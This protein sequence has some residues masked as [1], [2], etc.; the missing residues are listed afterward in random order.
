L[1]LRKAKLADVLGNLS[2]DVRALNSSGPTHPAHDSRETWIV[3]LSLVLLAI[4]FIAYQ[5]VWR[6][7][8]VWD[9]DELLT[10]NPTVTSLNLHAPQALSK[11][12]FSTASLD[13]YPMTYTLWW[14]EL[15]LWGNNPLGFHLVNVL[16]HGLSALL[17]WR[18]LLRLKIPSAF[19]AAAIFALHPVNV[20]SVAWISEGKN[21]LSMF[22]FMAA[23]LSYVK[24]EDDISWRWYWGSLALF[25]LALFS[26]TA[27]APLPVILLGLAWAR[28]GKIQGADVM[29]ALPFLV[30]ALAECAVTMWF[31]YHRAVGDE[32]VRADSFWS[33]LAEA[34]WAVWFYLYKAVLPVNL[35]F[36]Y[37]K[38]QI[39]PGNPVSYLPGLLLTVVLAALWIGAGKSRQTKGLAHSVEGG[40]FLALAYF[41]V[42]LLPVLGFLN[43]YFMRYS[44][45][46][47]HWQYFALIGPIVLA[48]AFVRKPALAAVILLT[49]GFL[50]WKQCGLYASSETLWRDT[51]VKNP[52]SAIVKN[53][54]SREL[55]LQN[56]VGEAII[57][58]KSVLAEH[59]DDETARFN[60]AS[61]LVRENRIDEAIV[62]YGEALRL[63]PNDAN[64]LYNLAQARVKKGDFNS[65]V[66]DF[67]EAIRMQPDFPEAWCNLGYALLQTHRQNEAV[68]AYQKALALNPDYAL[69]H[70]DLG[71]I[72]LKMGRVGDAASH[73]QQAVNTDPGF[74]EAHYNLA[75]ALLY[76][77]RVDEAVSQ[78]KDALALRLDLAAAELKL[79]AIYA[80]EGSAA[81]AVMHYEKAIK[82]QPDMP[83]ALGN[84]AWLLATSRDS[85]LRNGP[86]ALELARRADNLAKGGNPA[87]L[88]SLAAAEAECGRFEEAVKTIDAAL[89]MAEKNK[90]L[91]ASLK[92]QREYYA[93][94][95][96]YRQ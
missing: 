42:M 48:A 44:L 54:L 51:L 46:A 3:C 6:A 55:L 76:L 73:F 67:Q 21:C 33:R 34:G 87:F 66:H 2:Q 18:I 72:L 89:P 1:I 74:A 20:E 50:T 15:R 12:W 53:D 9:D 40:L 7:G 93:K 26:K 41:I 24:Y 65:A 8:F 17:L 32:V 57:L 94:R 61:A 84:L 83:Y 77:N 71:S 11:I 27:A 36:I 63:R 85:A 88:G 68:A 38:W 78:Y 45:V 79:G 10:A 58:C 16:L 31:H 35:A 70:N 39:N 4:S 82:I 23:L 52:G 25:A 62:Q 30:I 47:D 64:L 28:R 56:R 29:R 86:R 91:A 14:L 59:P 5:P 19:L 92:Q 69:A 49:L 43:I 22:F 60:F 37:P 75:E 95:Q 96:P 81:E 13:Y 80:R 90:D